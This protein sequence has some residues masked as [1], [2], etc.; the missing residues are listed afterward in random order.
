[1]PLAELFIKS[2]YP[3]PAKLSYSITGV[4]SEVYLSHKH[5]TRRPTVGLWRQG[6]TV[7]LRFLCAIG[8]MGW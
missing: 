2:K 3:S 5:S 6:V 7:D 1:M 4:Y 8:V